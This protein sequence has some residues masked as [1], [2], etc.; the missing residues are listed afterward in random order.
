[1][2]SKWQKVAQRTYQT[3]KEFGAYLQSIQSNLLDLDVASAPN[4]TQI[5]YRIRQGLRS[6]FCAALY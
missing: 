3:G 4:E 6:E 5:I 1:M 2:Y